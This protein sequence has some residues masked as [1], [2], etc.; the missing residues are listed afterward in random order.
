MSSEVDTESVPQELVEPTELGDFIIRVE[1][2]V[3]R[4]IVRIT[5]ADRITESLR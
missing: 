4:N 3:E 2:N 5:S 1:E